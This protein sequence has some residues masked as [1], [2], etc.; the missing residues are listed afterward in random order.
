M[1]QTILKRQLTTA[2]HPTLV[3]RRKIQSLRMCYFS[4][5]CLL[6]VILKFGVAD[7]FAVSFGI[8][9]VLFQPKG[10]V[11]KS[12]EG[13]VQALLEA[14]DMFIDAFWVGKVGG[15]ATE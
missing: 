6:F 11:T 5:S 12:A 14:S 9:A 7:G 3:D 10:L 4:F 13:N 8:G 15:G 2:K 1:K